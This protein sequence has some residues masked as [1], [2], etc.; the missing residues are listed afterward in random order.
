MKDWLTGEAN[1]SGTAPISPDPMTPI[2]SEQTALSNL[3][4]VTLNSTAAGVPNLGQKARRLCG[5]LLQSPRFM[6]SGI[7]PST[8]LIAPRLRVCNGAPC[9]YAEMCASYRS[10]LASFGKYIQCGNHLVQPGSP[11]AI[12]VLSAALADLC[13]RRNC[14]LISSKAASICERH[15]ELCVATDFPP[16]PMPIPEC[17][18]VGCPEP[19]FDIRKPT[20]FV[21][22]AAGGT[23]MRTK[24]V[25]VRSANNKE[26][27]PLKE[28]T[29]LHPGDV[30]R[31]PP[32]AVF[33]ARSGEGTFATPPDGMVSK[34]VGGQ[35]AIDGE[36]IEAI[37][38]GKLVTID[39][40]LSKGA[41]IGARD[42]YGR[43]PVMKAAEAGN[44]QLLKILIDRGA[45]LNAEDS[46][47]LSAADLATLA[48]KPEAVD[49]LARRG[50]FAKNRDILD[51]APPPQ[52]APWLLLVAG[53]APAATPEPS[54]SMTPN[55]AWQLTLSG[56]LGTRAKD[57]AEIHKY[58][59]DTKF[60]YR[61]EAG[62][63]PD[64]KGAEDAVKFYMKQYFA[65]EHPNVSLP[66]TEKQR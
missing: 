51:R 14:F 8:G 15:P 9:T 6:L 44:L 58:W 59:R 57:M 50:A 27:R 19:W 37:D 1:I 17:G 10:T 28:A 35:R 64:A 65:K 62:Q 32:G 46:R 25:T 31:I 24:G 63:L 16:K 41:D 34:T 22:S 30:L 11:P 23:V 21:A 56:V 13:P 66:P 12:S 61:G 5:I 2:P 26:F 48:K 7:E 42:I 47:G 3:F 49:L 55:Q 36:L 40:L 29:T 33:E 18:P 52:E 60:Y 43:T 39:A 45:D 20:M 4:G 53:G 38:R 54:A